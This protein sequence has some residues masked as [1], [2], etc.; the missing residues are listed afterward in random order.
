MLF[1]EGLRESL[2]DSEIR[3]LKRML[4]LAITVRYEMPRAV[5][6]RRFPRR[7]YYL[8]VCHDVAHAFA[9]VFG[10]VAIDGEHMFPMETFQT[11]A[12]AHEGARFSTLLHS[13]VEFETSGGNRF[14]LDIYP[15]VNCPVLPVVLRHPNAAYWVPTDEPRV[16]EL[17]TLKGRKFMKRVQLVAD[18]MRKVSISHL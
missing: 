5:E 3:E 10:G 4:L 9:Q 12:G 6:W 17:A 13:W 14:I 11:E 2:R 15:D 18:E 8:P 16:R 1:R 7:L